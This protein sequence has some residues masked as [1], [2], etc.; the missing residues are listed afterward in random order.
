MNNVIAIDGPSAAGKSTVARGVAQVMGYLYVDSGALYRIVTWQ[1]LAHGIDT[2]DPEAV[3]RFAETLDVERVVEEGAVAY[4][5]AGQA[6]GEAIRLPE[7]NRHV[8]PVATVPAVRDRVTAWLREMRELGSLVVEGRDIGSV[9]FPDTPARFYLNASAAERAR[10]RHSEEQEK[11]IRESRDEVLASLMNRDRIDS[12]RKAAPLKVA[13][14]A[15]VVDTTPL[16][17]REV[18]ET[19]LDH[20]PASFVTAPAG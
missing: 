13:D 15:M 11:G 14:G 12:G 7:I 20:L 3:A 17:I 6:P 10:R 16:G 4:R 1:C 5:I 2:A 18:I 8:S 9:V 19:I